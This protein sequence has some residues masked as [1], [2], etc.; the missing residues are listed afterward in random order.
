MKKKL[1]L[2]MVTTAI[3]AS[4]IG[5]GSFAIFTSSAQNT[6]NT[7]TSGTLAVSLNKP[8]GQKYFDI[9]N[10][11][12]GDG[13]ATQ[14]T[15]KNDGSLE[16]RYD[17]TTTLTGALAAGANGLKVT[18]RDAAGNVITPGDTN[19]VLASQ[20]S[21]TLTVSWNLP[22]AAGNEYQGTSAALGLFVNAEQTRNN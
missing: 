10:L 16:L 2:A 15:V 18:I 8:D 7:F 1:A 11:A 21:E 6:N 9:S 12:P 13:G 5:A 14:V 3:G 22:L 19:R 17:L 4:L 20:Q